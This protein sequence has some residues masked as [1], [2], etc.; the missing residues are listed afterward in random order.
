MHVTQ[1]TPLR[2]ST[3]EVNL[4]TV[5]DNFFQSYPLYTCRRELWTFTIAY[6]SQERDELPDDSITRNNTVSF[7]PKILELLTYLEAM[8]RSTTDHLPTG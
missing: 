8:R 1:P 2:V 6:I 3:A 4:E 7:C 5:L